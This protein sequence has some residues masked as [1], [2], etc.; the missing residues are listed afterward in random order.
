MSSTNKDSGFNTLNSGFNKPMFAGQVATSAIAKS[1]DSS[2]TQTQ[3]E[4][5]ATACFTVLGQ[6]PHANCE[7]GIPAYAC[8]P[9]SH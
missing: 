8:M 2:K 3:V 4:K 7:H 6:N 9:C 1:D 5:E